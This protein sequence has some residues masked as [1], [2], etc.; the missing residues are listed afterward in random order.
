MVD[1]PATKEDSTGSTGAKEDSRREKEGGGAA[2]V[3]YLDFLATK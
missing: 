1:M 3:F 2:K